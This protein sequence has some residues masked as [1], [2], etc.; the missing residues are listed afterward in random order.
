M[1]VIAHLAVRRMAY[2]G[3]V[4]RVVLHVDMRCPDWVSLRRSP[5]RRIGNNGSVTLYRP[6]AEVWVH[7][8]L[9]VR[10]SGIAEHGLFASEPI[11]AGNGVIRFG[12]RIVTDAQLEEAFAEAHRTGQYVDTLHVDTNRHLI[13][14]EGSIA[15][16][17]N[18]SCEPTVWLDGP[19]VLAARRD[20]QSDEEITVDY[21]TFSTLPNFT[22]PCHCAAASCRGRVTGNDWQLRELQNRYGQHWTPAALRL[23]SSQR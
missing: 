7:P 22:M 21:A 2:T 3:Q 13:L 1:S 5:P 4:A 15:H 14:P 20:I 10:A 16:F 9:E 17:G 6:D 12:G 18:H 11:A 19:F 23:I 8:A